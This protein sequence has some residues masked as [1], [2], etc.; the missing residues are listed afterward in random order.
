MCSSDLFTYYVNIPETFTRPIRFHHLER[1]H[2]PYPGC[3]KWNNTSNVWDAFNAYTWEF[4]PKEGQLF[5]FPSSLPHDTIG[6][7]D[8]SL[9]EGNPTIEMLNENRI[10]LAADVVLTYKDQT[11]SPLGLQPITNWRKF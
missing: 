3:I 6:Q 4:P 7:S 2:E 8:Q 10:C 1:K 11:A 9:D 5:V